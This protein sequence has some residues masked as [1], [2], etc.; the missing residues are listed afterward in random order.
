[1]APK[2]D[3]FLEGIDDEVYVLY[4]K[5]ECDISGTHGTVTVAHKMQHQHV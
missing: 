2:T 4:G 3:K 1:M 5:G